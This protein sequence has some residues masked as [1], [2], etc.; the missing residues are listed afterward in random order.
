L[1]D[2]QSLLRELPAVD[3][4]L[5]EP[6]LEELQQRLPRRIVL[7]A[8]QDT[9]ALY[10][11]KITAFSEEGDHRQIIDLSLTLLAQEAAALAEKSAALN[12]KPLINAT[13]VIIHT[14]LGRAP[15]AR[16][17]ADA[18]VAVA[19]NYSN[20]ELSLDSGR[21]GSRQ[22]HIENL[23]CELSGSEAAVVVNNNAAAVFLTL[24]T[25]A[26]G[27]EVI[28]SRGQLVE[29]G[30]SFR[31]PDIMTASGARLVEI[32]TTNK[33][34]LRDYEAVVTENSAAF[35][36]VHTSN[37][38]MVGFTAEVST[39]DLA[40]LAHKNN[41]LLIEDLGS[42]VFLDLEKYLPHLQNLHK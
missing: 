26:F 35:L 29:I 32:G 23:L 34:Y 1:P 9:I 37:Y 25:V 18:L 28:V 41:L 21:R 5:R 10:R 24:N 6:L 27:R 38:H 39:P 22:E 40:G 19:R 42:G 33:T 16:S 2:Y 20:L 7:Q 17:A 36:K 3:R 14:N 13:G 8:A 12:L 30:G 31:I 15:L 11:K 4:L